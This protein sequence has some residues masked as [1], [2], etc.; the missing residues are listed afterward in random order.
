MPSFVLGDVRFMFQGHADFIQAFQESS[1]AERLDFKTRQKTA[2]TGDLALFQI[3]GEVEVTGFIAGFE[4]RD[5]RAPQGHGEN[6]VLDA[7]VGED[8]GERRRDD[9]P[10]TVITQRPYGVLA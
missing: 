7:V 8:I 6:S 2:V 5:F 3:H 10:E 1:A 4:R 9:D